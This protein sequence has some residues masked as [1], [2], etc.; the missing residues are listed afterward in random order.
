MRR[1]FALTLFLAA[2]AAGGL[3]PGERAA[4]LAPDAPLAVSDW[5]AE[6]PRAVL[7]ALHGY[8]DHAESVFGEAAPFWAEQG[9]AVRA[10][11]H[12]GFGRNPSRGVWPGVD[13][14]IEDAADQ[15]ARLR[16]DHPDAPLVLIGESMGA[17][18]A[19][20]A[21]GE[22]R[23]EADG[24]ILLAPAI[25]GGEQVFPVA[26]AAVWTMAQAIP[27]RRWTGEGLVSFQASDD[28][29]MLRR[30]AA[31][32]LYLGSPNAREILGLIRV[33]D[34]A[35]A[36]APAV[37]TPTL[38]LFGAR[39]ELLRESAVRA[40][41][42]TIPGLVAFRLYP[43]GWHLLLRDLQKRRVWEDVADF[44]LSLPEPPA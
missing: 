20:A 27:D 44:V 11:D 36:A 33:M 15:A 14:L 21:V 39:D 28:I 35:A 24:L 22:G 29:E 42:E 2:C 34:R 41:A 5:P 19:L 13:A 3:T 10:Y 30:L 18:V 40:V 6:T 32:P 12:R 38:V 25:A 23:I 7:L 8:G 9:V 17:G 16:A 43:D 26:R 37:E 1:A 31:D 4:R